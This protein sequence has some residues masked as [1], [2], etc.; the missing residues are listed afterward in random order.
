MKK[1]YELLETEIAKSAI[2][3]LDRPKCPVYLSQDD[4]FFPFQLQS[5]KCSVMVSQNF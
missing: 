5:E 2:V 3:S 1:I 4:K